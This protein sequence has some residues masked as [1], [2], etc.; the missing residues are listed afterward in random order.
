MKHF[1]E[2]LDSSSTNAFELF[3]FDFVIDSQLSCW[4]IEANMSPA[5]DERTPWL[6]NM[7][8]DMADGMLSIIEKKIIT[9]IQFNGKLGSDAILYKDKKQKVNI[10]QWD[11]IEVIK[12]KNKR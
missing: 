5:C 8:D 4:L 11:K 3:G 6:T 7:L 10:G 1:A 2:S 12:K 9:T